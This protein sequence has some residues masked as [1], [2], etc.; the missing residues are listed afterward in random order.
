MTTALRK[1]E[2]AGVGDLSWGTHFC[3]FYETKH[4]LL[5]LVVPYFKAGLETKEFC[6]WVIAEPLTA[7]DAK[8]TL[9]QPFPILLAT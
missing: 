2:I 5:D 4:D 7:E 3:L 1:T 9:Q 6:L 8:R